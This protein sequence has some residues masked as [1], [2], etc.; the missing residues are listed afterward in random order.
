MLTAPL[1]G[2]EVFGAGGQGLFPKENVYLVFVSRQW[3]RLVTVER[4]MASVS[5]IRRWCLHR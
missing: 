1:E 3:F 5:P 4:R 2:G